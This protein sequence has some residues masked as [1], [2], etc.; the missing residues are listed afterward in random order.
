M[1]ELTNWNPGEP[2]FDPLTGEP[3]IDEFGEL[4]EVA[5]LLKVDD[6]AAGRT[7][8]GDD[9]ANAAYYRANKFVGESIRDRSVGVPYLENV[10]GQSDQLL[11]ASAVVGE[12]S[13]R[14]PGV[15]GIV[16]VQVD[17]LDPSTRVLSWSGVVLR[18]DGTQQDV[19]VQT[20][21]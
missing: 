21:G 1:P 6:L 11:A 17:G 16:A 18:K 14:T 9:V 10:L 7:L 2:V 19:N 12:V 13:A 15:A 3:F 4:V 8:D 20:G 5:P